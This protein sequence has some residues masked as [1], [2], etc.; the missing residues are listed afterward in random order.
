MM[1]DTE[2]F[3]KSRAR[4]ASFATCRL[5]PSELETIFTLGRSFQAEE[6]PLTLLQRVTIER[7]TGWLAELS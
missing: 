2:A 3:T 1:C 4:F 7:A 6:G 5:K